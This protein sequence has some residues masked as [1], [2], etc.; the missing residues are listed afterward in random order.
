MADV[1]AILLAAGSAS[2]MGENKMFMRIGGKSVIERA[3]SA[4]AE[5]KCID[6]V[7]VVCRQEDD[8]RVTQA[9]QLCLDMPFRT[10]RGGEQRQDSVSNALAA[11]ESAQVVLV[12][13]GA[14]CFVQ[15]E[16]VAQCVSK[17]AETGAAAAGVRTTDTIK[18]V[19]NDMIQMTLD[20]NTLVNIQTPQA[21]SF[22]L[23]KKAH[24]QADADSFVGTDECSLV[25]RMGIPISFVEADAHNI[26]VTTPEDIAIG[27]HIV[28]EKIRVGSG[29]DVHRLVKGRRLILGGETI[30][31]AKGLMGHSDADVLLHA[32]MD[33]MF[34]AAAN[35]DIGH[36]FPGIQEFKDASSLNLLARTVDI[37]ESDG[38]SVSGIDAT[39]VMERPRLSPYIDNMRSNIARTVGID[40]GCVS[41]KATTTEGLG[42]EG[43]GKGVSASAI[44]TLVG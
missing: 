34:G 25:E 12:H 29:Y 21:F 35:R 36:H 9:A 37:I 39:V 2:R 5:S 28:G 3:M 19:E 32:I 7:I 38:F 24:R 14:R 11:I 13:D 22:E 42:F 16:V 1:V 30:A 44:V 26:K 15:P 31:Y 8:A 18:Q 23:L 43:K 17:A 6:E 10:V 4:I 33:A 20:R 41:V 27:R 40:I